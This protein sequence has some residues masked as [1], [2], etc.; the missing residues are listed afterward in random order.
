MN[1]PEIQSALCAAC[2]NRNVISR[3]LAELGVLRASQDCEGPDA[4]NLYEIDQLCTRDELTLRHGQKILGVSE[5]DP[6]THLVGKGEPFYV[7]HMQVAVA[8]LKDEAIEHGAQVVYPKRSRYYRKK[9][10]AMYHDYLVSQGL[11]KS[12]KR[13]IRK[14]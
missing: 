5:A 3:K 7:K 4:V 6:K 11:V 12:V 1:N 9:S 8:K 10:L 13:H 14:I 2:P